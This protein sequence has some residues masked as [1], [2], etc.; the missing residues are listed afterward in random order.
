MLARWKQQTNQEYEEE[1]TSR[2]GLDE[3]GHGRPLFGSKK[4]EASNCLD[5]F[6]F[7]VM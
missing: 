7:T 6:S 3:S 5:E 4:Y 1:R 2:A